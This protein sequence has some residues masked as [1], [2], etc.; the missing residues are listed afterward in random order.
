MSSI[1]SL[2][3]DSTHSTFPLFRLSTD[4]T[5]PLFLFRLPTRLFLS[6][7]PPD[8]TV[9]LFGCL[10]TQTFLSFAPPPSRVSISFTNCPPTVRFFHL[11]CPSCLSIIPLFCI[12][13]PPSPYFHPKKSILFVLFSSTR[14]ARR[15]SLGQRSELCKVCLVEY[16]SSS[17][18]TTVVL[19][20]NSGTYPGMYS[21]NTRLPTRVCTLGILGYLSENVL[22]GYAGIYPGMYSG[23][24]R[25]PIHVISN[26]TK[27]ANRVPQRL[28]P[29]APDT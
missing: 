28:I 19:Y 24:T 10:L 20:S 9:P 26:M 6:F 22:C 5:F 3:P 8:P 17:L 25:V 12:L 23:G 21:G 15:V 4:S 27:C 11:V 1:L 18:Y 14:P 16:I 7:V 2:S 13:V 29:P